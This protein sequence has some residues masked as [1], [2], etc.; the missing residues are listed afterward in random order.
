MK[1]S[2]LTTFQAAE[3]M[4]VTPDSVLKWIKSGKLKALKTPGGHNRIAPESVHGFLKSST[5]KIFSESTKS[6]NYFEYCWQFNSQQNDCIQECKDC[7]VFKSRT[8]YCFE[9]SNLSKEV[10]LLKLFCKSS[11]IEC[12]YYEFL[13]S[14][15]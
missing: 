15:N 14:N 13:K 10:G 6:P 7:I 1:K 11:C 12:R 5:P 2:Y 9:M 8:K 3:I 4:S